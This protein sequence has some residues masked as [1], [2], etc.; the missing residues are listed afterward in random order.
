[1]PWHFH[2]LKA[3]Q[4]H[5]PARFLKS[6]KTEESSERLSVSA[7]LKWKVLCE[8]SRPITYMYLPL[9]PCQVLQL[10]SAS[11]M[12][13]SPGH[14]KSKTVKLIETTSRGFG[15]AATSVTWS[16]CTTASVLRDS[17]KIPRPFFLL[18]NRAFSVQSREKSVFKLKCHNRDQKS[19]NA[20]GL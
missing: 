7:A 6:E 5:Y 19:N 8:I 20:E 3:K 14:W 15:G 12:H 18:D 16:T 9:S 17:W 10:C 4:K 11:Q 13:S 1:M 2:H